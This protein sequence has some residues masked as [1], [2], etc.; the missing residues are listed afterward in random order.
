[1]GK[2]KPFRHPFEYAIVCLLIGVMR[3]LPM[4][5]GIFVGRLL[6]IIHYFVD[7]KHRHETMQHLRQAFGKEKSESELKQ[8]AIDSYKGQGVSLVE[9][10]YLQWMTS[11]KLLQWVS[12]DGLS[13]YLEA[14]K[15]GRGVIILT[16]HVGNWELI[17]KVF[18]ALH[19]QI[20]GTVRPLDNP[21]LN[22]LSQ[23][24]REK[25]GMIVLNKFSDAPRLVSLFRKGESIGFLLDQNTHEADSVFVDFFGQEAATNKGVAILA[26][27][28]GAPV[29]PVF[30]R[31]EGSRHRMIISPPVSIVKTPSY[32]EDILNSTALFTKV[33]EAHIREAPDQWLWIHRRW[34]TKRTQK[35]HA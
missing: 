10:I 6:G 22:R 14:K 34:K 11:E 12:V 20:H 29:I 28:S 1:M 33:I 8:I 35:N 4:R 3:I 25:D 9:T 23:S 16:G 24:W 7:P 2:S 18:F 13:H 31:R 30:M 17:P 32:R 27:R 5:L 15:E 26:L 21:Y 19:S